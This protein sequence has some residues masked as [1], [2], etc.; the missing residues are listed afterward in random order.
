MYYNCA[1]AAVAEEKLLLNSL[2]KSLVAWSS[3]TVYI[4]IDTDINRL[5]IGSINNLFAHEGKIADLSFI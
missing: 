2:L 1:L 3:D 5:P 4:A